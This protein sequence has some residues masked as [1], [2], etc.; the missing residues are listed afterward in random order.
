MSPSSGLAPGRPARP[1]WQRVPPGWREV[2]AGELSDACTRATQALAEAAAAPSGLRRRCQA[3]TPPL[4]GIAHWWLTDGPLSAGD[5]LLL[6]CV[7]LTLPA[8]AAARLLHADSPHRT[9]I[10]QATALLADDI[11]LATAGP[12]DLAGMQALHA[13]VD[14]A[15]SGTGVGGA[16]RDRAAVFLC[17]RLRPRLFPP[18]TSL[19]QAASPTLHTDRWQIYRAVLDAPRV[20]VTLGEVRQVAGAS[21]SQMTD[22]ALLELAMAELP[23]P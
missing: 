19:A 7:G 20:R 9:A 22:L 13:T 16:D 10:L 1:Y 18:S 11:S 17:C 12:D 23:A 15:L 14:A 5:L 3:P 4:A 21:R 2:P 8:R 6:A